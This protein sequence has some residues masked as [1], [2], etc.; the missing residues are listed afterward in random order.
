MTQDVLNHLH[1]DCPVCKSFWINLVNI[2]QLGVNRIL[3]YCRHHQIS[4]HELAEA[5]PKQLIA[6]GFKLK[7]ASAL[8]VKQ[9]QFT[10]RCIDWEEADHLNVVCVP[11]DR[12]YPNCL[13]EISSP[14]VAL[15]VKGN[16]ERLLSRQLAMVGSRKPTPSGTANAVE[17][18]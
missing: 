6:L 4:V 8:S 5:T 10:R 14:P 13:L 2:P 18:A 12:Y 11:G 3:S 17:P 1:A 9:Q 16:P 15:F 7:W